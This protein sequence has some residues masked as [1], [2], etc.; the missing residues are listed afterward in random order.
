MASRDSSRLAHISE[1][2]ELTRSLFAQYFWNKQTPPPYTELGTALFALYKSLDPFLCEAQTKH[3]AQE[4]F[5]QLTAD[6]LGLLNDL[7]ERLP[8]ILGEVGAE[9][10]ADE[11]S[12]R[13]DLIWIQLAQRRV[14]HY[15]F[16][17]KTIKEAIERSALAPC[18]L[19]RHPT[20]PPSFSKC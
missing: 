5:F 16:A 13:K 8:P 7:K 20:P 1:T 6:L 12:G 11:A 3:E 2:K 14:A 4:A 10:P 9:T 17:I 15:S 19:S 18:G